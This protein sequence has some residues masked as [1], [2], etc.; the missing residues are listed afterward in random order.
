[1]IRE[2]VNLLIKKKLLKERARDDFDFIKKYVNVPNV[3]ITFRNHL[4]MNINPRT[5]YATPI[6]LY[7]YPLNSDIYDQLINN[8]IPFAS[9]AKYLILFKNKSPNTTINLS[10]I[11][12][13][14]KQYAKKLFSDFISVEEIDE[15][16]N[17]YSSNDP[18]STFWRLLYALASHRLIPKQSKTSNPYEKFLTR[19]HALKAT[20]ILL[21]AN[22]SA[23]VDMG[24]GIIHENEPTQ[25]VFI[26]TSTIDVVHAMDN[27]LIV[28][29]M[30]EIGGIVLNNKTIKQIFGKLKNQP[31]P[32][33]KKTIEMLEIQ[34]DVSLS[35][36]IIWSQL[37]NVIEPLITKYSDQFL[38]SPFDNFILGIYPDRILSYQEKYPKFEFNFPI[39][40]IL[41][42]Y[43]DA[44]SEF[45]YDNLLSEEV[46]T[47]WWFKLLQ[48][49]KSELIQKQEKMLSTQGIP[50]EIKNVQLNNFIQLIKDNPQIVDGNVDE[51]VKTF[52]LSMNQ[53][54]K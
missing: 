53:E 34:Y 37:Y 1:M 28:K 23:V 8:D 2:F 13:S 6:G 5:N 14:A 26:D 40:D 17:E 44:S 32:V 36:E 24:D 22:V 27:P 48:N 47:Q 10:T 49:P 38:S 4:T 16:F 42:I 15:F 46:L 41:K 35:D 43:V 25:A 29:D 54:L 9:E 21:S 30:P 39:L 12:N 50:F 19:Q 3:F 18:A 45:V 11:G 31:K 51:L 7:A 52:K 33:V 20:K